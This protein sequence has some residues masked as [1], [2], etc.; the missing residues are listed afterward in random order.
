MKRNGWSLLKTFA[1]HKDHAI[2]QN[3]SLRFYVA[4]LDLECPW[5]IYVPSLAP[6]MGSMMSA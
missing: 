1:K 4:F 6:G 3:L 2:I 5:I